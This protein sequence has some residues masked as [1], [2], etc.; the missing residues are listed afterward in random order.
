MTRGPESDDTDIG[1]LCISVPVSPRHYAVTDGGFLLIVDEATP[2]A[3]V[4]GSCCF[5]VSDGPHGLESSLLVVSTTREPYESVQL[6]LCHS[7][8]DSHSRL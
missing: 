7:T 8:V 3:A 5:C 2:V 4:F 1:I 6:H